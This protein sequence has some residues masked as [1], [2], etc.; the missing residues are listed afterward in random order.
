[1]RYGIL[2][3]KPL[4]IIDYSFSPLKNIFQWLKEVKKQHSRFQQENQ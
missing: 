4:K 1:M 2:C 3:K